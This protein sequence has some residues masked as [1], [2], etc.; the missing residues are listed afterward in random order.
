[1]ID[2]TGH[3]NKMKVTNLVKESLDILN[4]NYTTMNLNIIPLGSYDVMVGMD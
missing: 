1:V 4:G 2:L 3:K